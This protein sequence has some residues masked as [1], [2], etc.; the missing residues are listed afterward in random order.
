[1]PAVKSGR[2]V[3]EISAAVVDVYISLETTSV[4]SPIV[5]ANTAVGSNVGT[6]TRL[7]RTGGARD[8]TRSPPPRGGRR[9]SPSRLCV[10]RTAEATSSSGAKAQFRAKRNQP[11]VVAGGWACCRSCCWRRKKPGG[12]KE[13]LADRDA[14][15]PPSGCEEVRLII[16]RRQV[17]GRIA[18]LGLVSNVGDRELH[19]GAA[20]PRALE[21]VRGCR[22]GWRKQEVEGRSAARSEGRRG[23]AV[24][25]R[26]AAIIGAEASAEA[27]V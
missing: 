11:G 17:A 12:G 18:H 4:V 21:P 14:D 27:V 15:R 16:E 24:D 13:Q 26:A 3:I 22:R 10:P 2:S 23:Q 8:R 25:P 5:R 20:Q 1:M 7:N 9:S 19:L 6:S